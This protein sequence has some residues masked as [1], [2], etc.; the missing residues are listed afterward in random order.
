[1]GIQSR[2]EMEKLI[3]ECVEASWREFQQDLERR[4]VIRLHQERQ[5][6]QAVRVNMAQSISRDIANMMTHTTFNSGVL[7]DTLQKLL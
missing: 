4:I 6:S 5:F 7:H 1:M 2:D 3:A